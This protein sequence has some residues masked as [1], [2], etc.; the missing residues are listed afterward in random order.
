MGALASGPGPMGFAVG[1]RAVDDRCLP[2]GRERAAAP[3]P[4]QLERD[5]RRRRCPRRPRL[6]QGPALRR[7]LPD[8]P[9]SAQRITSRPSTPR[10]C[11]TARP[12]AGR[13]RWSRATSSATARTSPRGSARPATCGARRA[14]TSPPASRHP[15]S[16]VHAWMASTGHCQ[17][18]LNPHLPQRR[19]RRQLPPGQGLRHRQ[20]HLD[21]GLR[22]RDARVP[23]VGQLRPDGRLSVLSRRAGFYARGPS[24]APSAPAASVSGNGVSRRYH[25]ASSA[26]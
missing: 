3:S 15:A 11:S 8:Q 1:T 16:V 9:A 22:A 17:N 2:V 23:A 14:R 26:A 7:R 18:I 13:T 5:M 12:R 10:R 24:G 21:P 19:H 25:S 6:A 20:R 4:F